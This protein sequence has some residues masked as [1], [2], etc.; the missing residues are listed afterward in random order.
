MAASLTGLTVPCPDGHSSGQKAIVTP[1]KDWAHPEN[2]TVFCHSGFTQSN[3]VSLG[4]IERSGGKLEILGSA[5]APGSCGCTVK[6][7]GRFTRLSG[8]KD[9]AELHFS[10]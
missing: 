4:V 2:L 8:F 6:C 5:I 3:Q 9:D 7:K 1:K 10:G